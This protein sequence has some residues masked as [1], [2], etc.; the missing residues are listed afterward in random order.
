VVSNASAWQARN[1]SQFPWLGVEIRHLVALAAVDRAR[2]FRG[3]ADELGYGQSAISQR[4]AQLERV[5]GCRLV[6]R[7][8]GGH[9]VAVTPAGALLLEHVDSIVGRLKAARADVLAAVDG[10]QRAVRVGLPGALIGRLLP[11]LA[12]R[13]N[14]A[15]QRLVPVD[16]AS[17][18]ALL[19]LLDESK[20][21][22]AVVELPLEGGRY[23]HR[24]LQVDPMVLLVQDDSPLARATAPL[25]A[26]ALARLPLIAVKGSRAQHRALAMLRED[27]PAEVVL[28]AQSEH[29]AQAF[30]GAGAGVAIMPALAVAGGDTRVK[31]LSLDHLL[32]PRR[33]AACWLRDRRQIAGPHAVAAT[34]EAVAE[35]LDAIA[36]VAPAAVAVAA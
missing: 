21:D 16:A 19:A 33:L 25:T 18:Q 3:A 12:A 6:Q 7:S 34:A 17:D 35:E 32:P 1:V 8:R 5:V 27:D 24:V 36:S 30:V 4:I 13:L 29:T 10:E 20:L 28:E 26:S 15:G 2:S 9:H 11:R 31:A 23:E 22:I 14:A